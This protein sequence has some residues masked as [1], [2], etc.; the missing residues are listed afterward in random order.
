MR[1]ALSSV[2]RHKQTRLSAINYSTVE[3]LA[4]LHGPAGSHRCQSQIMI[5]NRDFYRASAH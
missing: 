1:G 2:S 5:E 3:I 4:T